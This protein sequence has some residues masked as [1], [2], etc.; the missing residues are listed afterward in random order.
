M[1]QPASEHMVRPVAS[2]DVTTVYADLDGTLLGPG[3]SLFAGPQQGAVTQ[4]AATAVAGLATAGV[5]LVLMSGRNRDQ[6]REAARTLGA[7]VFIAEIGGVIVYRQSGGE[8]V[9][10]AGAGDRR[11][12]GHEAIQRSG[13]AGFLLEAYRG[14]LEPHAPW[15]FLPRECSVLLRG[16]VDLD[17]ARAVLRD[18]GYGW[19]DLQDN[20]VIPGGRARFPW[21]EVDHARAYHLVPAGVSKRS[22]IAM[23]RS[24]RAVDRSQCIAVGDGPADADVAPEVGAV[25]IV[26]NGVQ[27]LDGAHVAA[28]VFVTEGSHGAGFAEAVA[29]FAGIG[30]GGRRVR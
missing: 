15:A 20:G 6:V 12:S 18:G 7:T 11:R 16:Q 4:E 14:R 19:L 26:S 25:F 1:L 28:N 3:G 9:V 27:A 29:P 10:R 30:A 24:R 21:L 17:E 8:E 22:A 5:D 23:D 13:A 2:L